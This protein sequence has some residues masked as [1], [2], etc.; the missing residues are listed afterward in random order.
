MSRLGACPGPGPPGASPQRRDAA[1]SPQP[2][3]LPRQGAAPRVSG[4]EA[5]R[6]AAP[7]V[8]RWWRAATSE[9]AANSILLRLD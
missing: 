7:P 1:D 3:R 8:R 2:P 6:G 9:S 4:A 5:D